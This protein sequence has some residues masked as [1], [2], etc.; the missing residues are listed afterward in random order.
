[1]SDN[2]KVQFDRAEFAELRERMRAIMSTAKSKLND[3][4][5]FEIA[6]FFEDIDKFRNDFDEAS[7]HIGCCELC[8][9]PIFEG[10]DYAYDEVNGFRVCVDCTPDDE[11][12]AELAD[13]PPIAALSPMPEAGEGTRYRVFVEDA[14]TGEGI[15]LD[16]TDRELAI[17]CAQRMVASDTVT[18]VHAMNAEGFSI[19]LWEVP[20]PQP[21]NPPHPGATP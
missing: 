11:I 15:Q 10:D 20:L 8:E 21:A 7:G 14:T 4:P 18:R 9:S 3:K 19:F 2:S 12:A 5:Y 17:G 16:F 6:S 1:M 13:D